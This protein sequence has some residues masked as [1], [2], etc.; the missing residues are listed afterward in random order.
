MYFLSVDKLWFTHSSPE[1]F[2]LQMYEFVQL[3]NSHQRWEPFCLH[4]PTPMCV[5]V[6]F[7]ASRQ[8]I[9]QLQGESASLSQLK[10]NRFLVGWFAL[11]LPKRS[12]LEVGGE[13]GEETGGCVGVTSL[14]P[15]AL[16]GAAF[17]TALL[18]SF[19]TGKAHRESCSLSIC[20]SPSICCWTS[21][22]DSGEEEVTIN[23]M[24]EAEF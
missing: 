22:K 9:M 1:W 13:D 16:A 18:G 19:K 8:G 4:V 21:S 20:C 17:L 23:V 14:L 3:Y 15:S 12:E 24:K 7:L 5:P 6:L 2:I 10:I 11:G